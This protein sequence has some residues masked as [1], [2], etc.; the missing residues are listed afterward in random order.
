MLNYWQT[1]KYIN[2][3]RNFNSKAYDN[4]KDKKILR[5]CFNNKWYEYYI[6][7]SFPKMN[8]KNKQY[9]VSYIDTVVDFKLLEEKCREY[10]KN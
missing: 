9:A 4:E 8:I 3:L 7:M 10:K 1:D 6:L 5:N 2:Y